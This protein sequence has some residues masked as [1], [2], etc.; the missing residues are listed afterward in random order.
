MGRRFSL[1]TLSFPP[2]SPEIWCSPPWK[3]PASL[4]T[5]RVSVLPKRAV[6]SKQLVP[7]QS[8]KSRLATAVLLGLF[9]VA[10]TGYVP[11]IA[12]RSAG[13]GLETRPL[14]RIER[15]KNANFVQYD[16]QV[17]P[18]GKLDP[19]E[20]VIAYWI[21]R[22][23]DGRKKELTAFQRTWYYGFKATY[24]AATNSALMEMA[25]KNLRE[26]RIHKVEGVYRGESIID[27]QPAFL[28]KIFVTS[29][30]SGVA[31]K[32]TSVELYGKDVRTGFDR[33]EKITP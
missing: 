2:L 14:F 21:R 9:L 1:L 31:R 22:A 29:V 30:V 13:K 24:D 12:G 11:A 6:R 17:A 25:A 26:I 18:D 32:V 8:R 19:K 7:G 16:V 4:A 10:M 15:S 5:A 20:P 28:D 27:G 23:E 3:G 33:Y